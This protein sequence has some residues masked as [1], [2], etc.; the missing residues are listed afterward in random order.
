M[1]G[2]IILGVLAAIILIIYLLLH[3]SVRAYVEFDKSGGSATVKYLCFTLFRY[4][5]NS[6]ENTEEPVRDDEQP[7]HA[8]EEPDIT[9]TELT[10]ET[11]SEPK[12]P[13]S[14]VPDEE[15]TKVPE[16][17]AAENDEQREKSDGSSI[18]DGAAAEDDSDS[19]DIDETPDKDKKSLKERWE[20]IKPFIP[21]GKKGLKKLLKLI[22]IRSLELSLTVGGSDPYSAGMN[23][24]KANQAFYP[25]LALLCTA[26][27]V[28]IRKT[29]INCNYDKKEIDFGGSFK[30]LV[31][32]SA[33]ICL[34]IYLGI[35]YLIITH[36]QKI[37][38]KDNSQNNIKDGNENE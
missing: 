33:L 13:D 22:R 24:Y 30:V 20:E 26:F 4:D 37:K 16:E 28:T 19:S 32:P 21:V 23:F 34:V 8:A 29:E 3:I 10:D 7:P 2:Y 14:E 38:Q 18:A 5:T 25:A 15:G 36:K 6:A 12:Q 31:R 9:F 35:N 11:D 1:V 17:E 27:S